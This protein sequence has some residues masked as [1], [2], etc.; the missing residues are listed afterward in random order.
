MKSTI[1]IQLQIELAREQGKQIC[2]LAQSIEHIAEIEEVLTR[3]VIGPEGNW[4][5]NLVEAAENNRNVLTKFTLGQ[6]SDWNAWVLV[7]Q[8]NDN[9]WHKALHNH[10]CAA[11]GTVEGIWIIG[12]EIVSEGHPLIKAMEN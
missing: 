2:F 3:L 1:D 11:A 9:I 10:A 5:P 6:R 7:Y 4:T 8:G 12:D